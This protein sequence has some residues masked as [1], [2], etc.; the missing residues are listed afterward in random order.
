MQK[1]GAGQA[2][3]GFHLNRATLG[4]RTRAHILAETGSIVK[5]FPGGVCRPNRGWG[6]ARW[7]MLSGT[8]EDVRDGS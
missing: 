3:R 8:K 4:D 1:A 5:A 6:F 7:S 2:L